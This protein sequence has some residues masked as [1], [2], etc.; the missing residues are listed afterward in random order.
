MRKI[1]S[2]CMLFLLTGCWDLQE[3]T[4]IGL[5]TALAIDLDSETGEY[6]L[7]TQFLRPAAQSTVATESEKPYI[8]VTATGGTIT[9]LLRNVDKSVDRRSFYAHNK[10][11]IISEELAKQGILSLFET[12]Q[13]D[14]QVRSYVWIGVAK[15]TE[16]KLI[17]EKAQTG[18][19]TIPANFLYNLF[20]DAGSDTVASNLLK[21]YKEVIQE[22]NNPVIGVIELS[23][24]KAE[25]QSTIKLKG[26]AVF[27]RDQLVGYLNDRETANYNWFKDQMENRDLGSL[28]VEAEKHPVS[29]NIIRNE[30]TVTPKVQRDGSIVYKVKIKQFMELAEQ[31]DTQHYHAHKD[32]RKYVLEIQK[33]AEEEM[34]N[35]LTKLFEKA[36]MEFQTDFLGF[37]DLLRKHEP[38]K[39]NEVKDNW[40]QAFSDVTFEI[41]VVCEIENTGL[42]RGTLEPSL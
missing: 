13:R 24:L 8:T 23:Q 11:I 31:Q 7:T 32:I 29:L 37:G 5:V 17:L 15:N 39:W 30:R 16:A 21:F 34:K 6:I 14:Q 33:R 42:I 26:G 22:G 41:D 12:F 3:I 35:R 1:V 36:Q 18:I 28:I 27:K 4:E 19:S 9:E 2:I 38:K 40:E 20:E 10:V 25:S